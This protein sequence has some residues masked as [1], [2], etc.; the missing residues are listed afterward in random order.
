MKVISGKFKGRLIEINRKNN[1][2]PTLS[3]IREDLFNLLEHNAKLNVELKSA[4][5][6]DLFC[7][8]GSIGIEALSRGA[9]KVIFNDIEYSNIEPIKEFLQKTKTSNFE[10]FNINGYNQKNEILEECDI[11]YLDPPY[12]HDLSFLEENLFNQISKNCLVI[13]ECNQRFI[14]QNI[15]VEKN[16]KNKNLYFIKKFI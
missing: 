10:I 6:C 11:L 5:F 13:L 14:Y 3:R 2:R 7:G 1:F 16:Y 15:L 12:D 9:K 4:I 8:S